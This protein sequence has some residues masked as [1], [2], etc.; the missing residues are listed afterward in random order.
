LEIVCKTINDENQNPKSTLTR[1]E[2][3]ISGWLDYQQQVCHQANI[4]QRID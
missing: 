3:R 2:Y 4:V 1:A